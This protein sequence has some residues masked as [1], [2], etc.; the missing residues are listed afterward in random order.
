M[1]FVT[2]VAR[3]VALGVCKRNV[4]Y[5]LR[6]ISTSFW[7][8]KIFSVAFFLSV[9]KVH[10]KNIV[11]GL[12]F[13]HP[14]PCLPC[15]HFKKTR[16]SGLSTRKEAEPATPLITASHAYSHLWI[17]VDYKYFAPDSNTLDFLIFRAS[18]V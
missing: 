17:T 5:R 12:A 1:F 7:T 4:I 14:F 2:F 3:G 16:F 9:S 10:Q 18:M 11:F 15:A 6:V 13:S 8:I